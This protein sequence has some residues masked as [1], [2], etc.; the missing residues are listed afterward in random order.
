[1][2]EYSNHILSRQEVEM[3]GLGKKIDEEG[4][5]KTFYWINI[6]K[7]IY[8]HKTKIEY[9]ERFRHKLSRRGSVFKPLPH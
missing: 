5:N 8:V 6:K 4:L 7:R 2:D 3:L 9:V 1:M